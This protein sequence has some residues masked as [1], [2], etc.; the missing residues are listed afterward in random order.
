MDYHSYKRE[1]RRQRKM[2]LEHQPVATIMVI[3]IVMKPFVLSLIKR[4]LFSSSQIFEK[5]EPKKLHLLSIIYI[6]NALYLIY[7]NQ[8]DILIIYNYQSVD[9]YTQF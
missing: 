6:L 9:I 1:K 8:D 4:W 7:I 5:V 2:N 3:N